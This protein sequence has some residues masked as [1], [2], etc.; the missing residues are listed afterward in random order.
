M[1]EGAPSRAETWCARVGES[2][3]G[4]FVLRREEGERGIG[5]TECP[6]C[7]GKREGSIQGIN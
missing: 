5:E 6:R 4:G 2:P 1:E 3:G 7:P